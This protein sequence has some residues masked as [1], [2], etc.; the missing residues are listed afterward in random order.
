MIRR[1]NR[2]I[3]VSLVVIVALRR[4]SLEPSACARKYL[5][6]ASVSWWFEEKIMSGINESMFSSRAIQIISQ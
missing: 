5:I 4:S 2:R 3:G 6:A 1:L